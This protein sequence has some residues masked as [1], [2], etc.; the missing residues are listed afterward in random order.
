ME[1]HLTHAM[2]IRYLLLLAGISLVFD[3][4][5]ALARSTFSARFAQSAIAG[6][7]IEQTTVLYLHYFAGDGEAIVGAHVQYLS[8]DM[9]VHAVRS[10]RGVARLQSSRI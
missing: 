5:D 2:L 1:P 8:A 4:G 6:P 3:G 10:Q 7:D 9:S